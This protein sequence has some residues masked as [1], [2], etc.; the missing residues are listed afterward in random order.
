[1]GGTT[2]FAQSFTSQTCTWSSYERFSKKVSDLKKSE[3]DILKSGFSPHSHTG[4]KRTANLRAARNHVCTWSTR[5]FKRFS[6]HFRVA[7]SSA[8]RESTHPA[9]TLVSGGP[10]KTK[11]RS[12][13]N[14]TKNRKYR[15]QKT[16]NQSHGLLESEGTHN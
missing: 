11:V 2:N 13:L 3:I 7:F 9:T 14:L 10:S 16:W 4:S 8:V 6:R 5:G 1:M 12:K 15:T